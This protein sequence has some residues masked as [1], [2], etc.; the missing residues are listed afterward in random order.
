V[1]FF[2]FSVRHASAS[3]QKL[4]DAELD[5]FKGEVKSVFTTVD[6]I[7]RHPGSAD[8]PVIVYGVMCHI[9][10]YDENG[11]SV[12]RGE[13]SERGFLGETT[14]YIRDED[15]TIR[16]KI[17]E[18]EK[19]QIF[20]KVVFGPFGKTQEE[21][22]QN[23]ILQWKQRLRYD[24]NGNMIEWLTF[25]A[26]GTETASTTIS[27]DEQGNLT[28][29]FDRGPNGSFR[30]HFTQSYDPNTDVQTFTNYNEDGTARLTFTAK[31]NKV[32]NYWQQPSDK[33]EYGSGM[34][35]NTAAKEQECEHHYPNGRIWH[36]LAKFADE[37]RQNPI[38]IELRDEIGQ[39]EMSAD[40]E[41]GFDAHGNWTN[42]SVWVWRAGS[43]ER[44]LQEVDKRTIAYWK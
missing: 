32:T 43:G 30:L 6:K 1:F 40:Y 20:Q 8:Y 21:N 27:F 17:S 12:K 36:V 9:C 41:Y 4:T 39:V 24:Q 23:G 37:R 22:Y 44:N 15:G 18:N 7:D 19:G 28:E 3:H 25:D 11:N 5:G 29:Q 10:E 35:F 14:R 13:S 16:E 42:R 34:C 31:D 2:V 38:R 26:V 33:H